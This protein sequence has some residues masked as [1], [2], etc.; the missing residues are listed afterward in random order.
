[1]MT[2]YHKNVLVHTFFCLRLTIR[3]FRGGLCV[4]LSASLPLTSSDESSDGE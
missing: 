2:Q 4:E 3:R 1:M